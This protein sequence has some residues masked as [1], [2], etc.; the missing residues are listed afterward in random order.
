MAS[1][2]PT[3]FPNSSNTGLPAGVNLTSSGSIVVTKS[4][5]VLDGLDIHGNVYIANGVSN[6][7]IQNCR[8]TTSEYAG[9]QAAGSGLITVQNCELNGLGKTDG[10]YGID[11]AGNFLNNNI[12]GFENG[13]SPGSNSV[14]KGNYIHNLSDTGHPDGIALHGGQSNVLIENNTV[15]GI[16]NGDVYITNDFGSI[17]NVTVNHNYLGGNTD[18]GPPVYTIYVVGGKPGG[19]TISGIS[20][21]DNY[22][23]KGTYG[24][25]EVDSAS[26][27]ASGN[28]ELALGTFPTIPSV[29]TDSTPTDPIPTDPTPTDPTPTDPTTNDPTPTDPTGH[30]FN[31]TKGADTFPSSGQSNDGD[32]TMYGVGGNDR[33]Y[34]G[35]GNDK[36]YG[37]AG[38]DFL[39]G[40][41]GADA[42]DGGTGTDTADYSTA[43]GGLSVSLL[44]GKD[45]W[46]D[47]LTSIE[48]VTGSG[49]N[50]HLTG[51]NGGN[52]LDGGAGNDVLTGLGGDDT[53]VVASAVDTVD[54]TGGGAAQTV[55]WLQ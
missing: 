40:G 5:T 37:G 29:P 21:T 20:I 32:D 30:T 33:L 36:L 25:I 1:T 14:V 18:I 2:I 23:E 7:T 51:N 43:K 38:N 46:G 41:P 54:E 10:S 49:L 11:A 15:I 16:G 53:Y 31:G 44:S 17:S 3:G 48:N 22:V 50:D 55:L 39:R 12:H 27:T 45:D 35:L 8:I 42:M 4:G 34:G 47:T 19:G 24:Y 26:A 13:I 28:H 52:V 6:V 9:I